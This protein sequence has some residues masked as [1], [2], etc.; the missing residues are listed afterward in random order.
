M[1]ILSPYIIT[2]NVSGLNSTIKRH[3]ISEWIFLKTRN[4]NMLLTRDSV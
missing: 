4:V 2:L 3:G 1:A